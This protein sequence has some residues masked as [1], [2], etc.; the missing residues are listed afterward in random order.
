MK[1]LTLLIVVALLLT[2]GVIGT[3]IWS[4]AHGGEFDRKHSTQ[5][6]MA[7]VGMQGVTLLLLVWAFLLAY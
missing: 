2:I 1:I 4:M 5:L 6:M 7:R 3:G